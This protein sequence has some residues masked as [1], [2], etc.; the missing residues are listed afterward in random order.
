MKVLLYFFLGESEYMELELRQ[1]AAC[2]THKALGRALGGGRTLLPCER[3][4]APSGLFLRQYLLYIQIKNLQK[5]LSNSEN[6][7]FFTKTTPLQF[8]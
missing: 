6:F 7:Y 1:M 8:C 2:G 4:V 3:L 5:V